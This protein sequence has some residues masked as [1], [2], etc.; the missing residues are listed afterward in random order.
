MQEKR[1]NL[2]ATVIFLS[3]YLS[4]FYIFAAHPIFMKVF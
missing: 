2:L 3:L 1:D 4:Q